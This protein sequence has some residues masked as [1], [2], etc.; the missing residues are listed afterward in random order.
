[1]IV[2]SPQQMSLRQDRCRQH[3]RASDHV[4]KPPPQQIPTRAWQFSILTFA[5]DLE[6]SRNM[7]W[8]EHS[9]L[10]DELIGL[11][12]QYDAPLGRI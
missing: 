2:S 11:K 10:K 12:F 8:N 3:R 1:M 7:R 6:A 4:G 5:S 9:G